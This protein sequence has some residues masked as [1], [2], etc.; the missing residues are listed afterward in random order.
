M[1]NMNRFWIIL[2][3]VVLG[4]G[5]LFVFTGNNS[6]SDV[7]F[8]GD[9]K[10]NQSD[11]HLRNGTDKKVTVI[12]YGDFQC[13]SCG[14]YYPILKELE[15][16]YK[17]Q[18]SFGFRHYPIIGIHP[19]AFAA[20]RAA[21]AASNQGKFFEMHD[22]L[23][24][25]QNAWGKVT[26]NQQTLF[27]GYAKDLGLDMTKFKA[28]YVSE[29]TANRINRDVS[30]AKQFSITGTPT[31]VINGVKIENPADKPAFE[32]VLNEAITKAGGTVPIT[33]AE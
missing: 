24:E 1:Y 21:E 5:A 26:T 8:T 3:V 18:V 11:D 28:D 27:E 30:S 19:N 10:K 31:F 23:Y 32:K 14:S 33:K 9:A 25:S 13:P 15:S 4:L 16:Q 12:E 20:A 7:N 6:G 2:A 29:A 22:I 17:E